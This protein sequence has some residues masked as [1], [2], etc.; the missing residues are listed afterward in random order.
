VATTITLKIPALAPGEEVTL[1]VT[2][3][4]NQIANPPPQIIRNNGVLVSPGKSTVIEDE[5]VVNVPM[6]N[7]T[8]K[9]TK[10]RP[11]DDE[12][13]GG[14]GNGNN[15]NTPTPSAPGQTTPVPPTVTNGQAAS[16]FTPPT[17]PVSLLPETGV[18][19]E[20]P[21]PLWAWWF[22]ALMA[23]SFAVYLWRRRA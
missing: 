5:A 21:N 4:V 17:L 23:M 7:I 1:Y 22:I 18:R 11:D 15:R 19:N 6:P 16:S 3:R 13:N 2:S 12:N 8:P 9:P 20:K 14:G 10:P